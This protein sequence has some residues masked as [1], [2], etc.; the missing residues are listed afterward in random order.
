ML[1]S[2]KPVIDIQQRSNIKIQDII[3]NPDLLEEKGKQPLLQVQ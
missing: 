3:G 1:V 2:K